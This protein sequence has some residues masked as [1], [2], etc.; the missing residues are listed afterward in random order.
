MA[1]HISEKRAQLM[2]AL[3]PLVACEFPLADLDLLATLPAPTS[4]ERT[5]KA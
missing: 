4:P 1:S 3:L 5:P 2:N